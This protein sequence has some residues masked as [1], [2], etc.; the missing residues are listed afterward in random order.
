MPS[1][2]TNSVYVPASSRLT[3]FAPAIIV[4]QAENERSFKLLQV[5]STSMAAHWQQLQLQ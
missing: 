4:H 1:H 2:L 5:S 3:L